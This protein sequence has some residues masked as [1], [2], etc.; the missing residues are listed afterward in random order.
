MTV[1]LRFGCLPMFALA[2]LAISGCDKPPP[3]ETTV[4]PAE[5][6]EPAAAEEPAGLEEEAMPEEAGEEG[7]EGVAEQEV[8]AA[9]AQAQLQSAPKKKVSGT[10]ELTEVEEGVAVEGTVEGLE[11]GKHGFHVHE[12][13]DCSAK[14]FKSAGGHFNPTD[15]KHGAPGDPEHHYGDMG[16]IEAGKDGKATVSITMPELSLREGDEGSVIGL[17]IVVHAKA[18]DLKSQPSGAAGARV[19]CGVITP[20]E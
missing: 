5:A 19:A 11:P 2:A 12:K 8:E 3:P 20:V 13:G 1:P 16:N 6:T 18:D 7:E 9:V 10:I 15:A 17:A 4:P 14:D